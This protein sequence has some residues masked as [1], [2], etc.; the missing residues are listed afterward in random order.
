MKAAATVRA[1]EEPESMSAIDFEPWMAREQ[2]R[3]YLL[4]LR[5]LRSSDEAD[6]ATQDVF[7]KAHRMLEN[8]K[9][10]EIEAPEKWLTTVA[11]HTCL[12]R[13]RSKRWIFWRRTSGQNADA[14]LRV[15]PASGVN[16]HNAVL[17]GEIRRRL[18][19]ALER[20]AP[21]QRTVFVLRHDEDRSLEE[22]AGILGLDVG[23]VKAHLAR[24]I[25]KL[26]EELRDLYVR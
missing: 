18:D 8:P 23:T 21:R 17:D 1:G 6:S 9:G 2:R 16:Q 15:S 12:D 11:V 10:R 25:R 19:A 5:L 4:C 14:L 3:I 26:R 7:L 13:L 24:A 22:I 20:L